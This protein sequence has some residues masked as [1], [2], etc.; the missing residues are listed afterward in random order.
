[1]I[2]VEILSRHRD[3]VAR[4]RCAGEAHIG[5]GYDNDVIVDDPYVAA[6]HLRVFRDESGALVA[7][8]LGSVNGTCLYRDNKRQ[9]R[10]VVNGDWPIQIGR[11]Y[12]RIRDANHGVEPERV[13]SAEMRSL[14]IL[15]A[16]L[17]GALI[18]T[19]DV[20]A[21]WLAETAEPKASNYLSP[22]LSGVGLVATWV[23]IW[24][25]ISR[26]FS[27]RSHFQRHLLV[28]LSGLLCFLLYHE[29]A[30]VFGFALLWRAAADYEYAVLWSVL[31][32]VCI[33]HMRAQGSA[34]LWLK[35]GFV[36]ALLVGI[37]TVQTVQ[38]FEALRSSGRHNTV[39]R[40]MPPA[41]RLAPVHNEDTFFAEI[42]QLRAELA[43]D[44]MRAR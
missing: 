12:L 5:R 13:A 3:V 36:A 4:F 40:L 28:A 19:I 22:L 42:G 39:R 38:Q 43:G 34:R 44:R 15:V 8:D 24:S 14:P 23:G 18:L 27:G 10:I 26:V 35:G 37:I 7:E 31:A 9:T 11:T 32:V 29:F 2:C 6:H 25:L 16:V 33:L 21:V 17:L 20:G 30:Q 1:M 41:L